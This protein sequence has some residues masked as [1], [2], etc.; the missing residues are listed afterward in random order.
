MAREVARSGS[1]AIDRLKAE[2]RSLAGAVGDRAMASVRGKVEGAAGRL[3]EYV[4]GGGG[5]GLMAAL[6]GARNVAE[7]K[8]PA[9]ARERLTAQDRRVERVLLELRLV[10]GCP[11]DIL[12]PVGRKAAADAVEHG[13]L[14]PDAHEDGRAALTTRGRLL[15]DAVVRDLTD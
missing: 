3:T 2:A 14:R 8:S 1:P 9:A 15:A 12:S 11:L 13:L 4:E 10:D 6:T 7:G 5:P